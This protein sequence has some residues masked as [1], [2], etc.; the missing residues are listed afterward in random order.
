MTTELT[1]HEEQPALTQLV[2][3]GAVSRETLARAIAA[4]QE[5][6]RSVEELLLAD[7]HVSRIDLIQAMCGAGMPPVVTRLSDLPNW[8]VILNDAGRPLGQVG[9]RDRTM[10][11]L[12]SDTDRDRRCFILLAQGVD[13]SRAQNFV[14]RILAEHYKLAGL[15]V[16]PQ[17]LLDVLYSE[18]DAGGGS[19]T[20]KLEGDAELH[21]EFDRIATEAFQKGASDIHISCTRGRGAIHM[22]VHGELEHYADL[23]EQRATD[24][25]SAIYNTLA[26]AGSTKEGFNAGKTQDAVI[27]R[28]LK[29]GNVRFRYSGLPIAPD[30]FDVTLRIIPIGVAARRK[31]AQELGYSED[32]CD[33]LERIF[34]H[35][36]GLILFAGTTGSGKSTTM[37]NMLSKVAEE[38]PGK[39]I[40]TVEEPVEYRVEGAYQ[41]PVKRVTG[42]RSDFLNVLRQI[43]RS[44]P[45]LLMVGEIRDG[46][47]A[48]LAIQAVRSGHLCVSTIHAD[49]AP[50]CYDRLVGMGMNRQDMASVGLVVGFIYQKLV[51]V[52]CPQCKIP[53]VTFRAGADARL[54]GVLQRAE[55]VAG[56]LDGIY[57]RNRNGCSH[58]DGRG[59]V[60]RTVCAEILRPTP[61]MLAAVGSGDSTTLWAHWRQ[62]ISKSDASR[63]TGRT[64]FEHAIHK[65]RMGLVAPDAIEA[66]FRFLDERPYEG[67]D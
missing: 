54:Q 28:T 16:V 31:S 3:N 29:V 33:A 7:G 40:R 9:Q 1:L 63:M 5:S 67:V 4:A 61:Q 25:V 65:M 57:M 30:G 45:D 2:K 23:P 37:A 66:E 36:S 24:L 43:M 20:L 41:T 42:D 17:Q 53:A 64:A 21:Q 47:T 51:P 44:D 62:T 58:C 10:A 39:K 18:W 12:N 32:Q 35:S 11:V 14:P 56:S 27:Q 60:G 52:L 34:S 26:E 13:R 55:D 19:K 59:V 8:N 15:L 38:R 22:R 6:G 50:I 49:G 46:D 48:E